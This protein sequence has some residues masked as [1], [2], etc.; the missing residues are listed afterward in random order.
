MNTLTALL[1]SPAAVDL[2]WSLLHFIWQG[3]VLAGLCALAWRRL[4]HHSAQARYIVGC[5][6]LLLM[7]SAPVLTYASLAKRHAPRESSWIAMESRTSVSPVD[8]D[9]ARTSG[10]SRNAILPT[11]RPETP[12]PLPNDAILP[13]LVA[14]W[15]GG[16]MFL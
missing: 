2:G 1:K 8:G 11:S 7:A 15:L 5:V 12:G 14:F 16:V 10:R 9:W 6:C 13:W 4:R 3:T